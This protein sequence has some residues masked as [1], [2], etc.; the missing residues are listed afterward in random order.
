[1]QFKSYPNSFSGARNR[2][3]KSKISPKSQHK[4]LPTTKIPT[5]KPEKQPAQNT[6]G[7][8]GGQNFKYI[9]RPET[10]KQ[11]EATNL[12]NSWGQG[13]QK[14][15]DSRKTQ[16]QCQ[17]GLRQQGLRQQGERQGQRQQGKRQ[18]ERQQGKGQGK[19]KQGQ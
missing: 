5:R 11:P 10:L 12:K 4:H 8:A 2:S 14:I 16:A 7:T 9:R 6:A 18:G 1:M 19:R 17:Q 13:G 3:N 15:K